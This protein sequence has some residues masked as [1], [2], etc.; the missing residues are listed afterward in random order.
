MPIT[1][2]DLL[3]LPGLGLS[4]VAGEAG[5]DHSI[6]WAHISELQ[7]PTPWLKGGEFLLTTGM[8]LAGS[9]ALQRAYIRRLVGADLAGLGFGL[10]FGFDEIP[11]PIKRAAEREGFPLLEVPYPVPFIAIAEAVSSRLAEDRLR[12]AQLAVDVHDRLAGLVLEGADATAVLEQVVELIDGWAVLF[13]SKGRTLATAAVERGMPD[14]A[15][16]WGG[17]ASSVL[18]PGGV[19]TASE[20]GPWGARVALAV[21]AGKRHEGALVCGRSRRFEQRDR[22]V[23]HHA[24][25]VLGLLLTSR[26]AVLDAEWK[27]AGDVLDQAFEGR[28]A[29]DDLERRLERVGFAPG[30][31][32]S[33]LIVETGGGGDGPALRD[34]ALTVERIVE[35]MVD[36]IRTTVLAERVAALVVHDD[37]QALA[38]EVIA[39]LDEHNR[40]PGVIDKVRIGA[41]A[42]DD[43]G[44]L[45]HGYLSATFAL[46]AAPTHRVASPSDLGSYGLLLG[47][48]AR[49][50][51]DGFVTMVLGPL[52]DR[53]RE[54]S[55]DLV[56]SVRAFIEAGGRWEAG[57]EALGIHRHTLRYRVRQAE[58]LL[59]RDLSNEDDRLEILLAL[60]A[61]EILDS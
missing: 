57:A 14:A 4:L 8:G 60:K 24:V 29:G 38:E 21:I 11:A 35:P 50:V 12:D 61:M 9:P 34:L 48:Q 22:I 13:D 58:E 23:V 39:R 44:T 42:V 33:I 55:S 31:P 7:D 36:S 2:R 43:I 46:R 40:V 45:H 5:L 37:A 17:L 27:V 51:L 53:D 54:R 41:A 59:G 26:R 49:P 1:V 25:T 15:R 19:R 16:L 56:T 32:L 18:A 3:D 30:A 52:V 20:T 6:R 10:G 47:A 28:Y